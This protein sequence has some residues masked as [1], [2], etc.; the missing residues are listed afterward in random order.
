MG[1][2]HR[3]ASSGASVGARMMARIDVV[4][5]DMCLVMPATHHVWISSYEGREHEHEGKEHEHEGK[6]PADKAK[7]RVLP[8]GWASR[9]EHT[10]YC[11]PTC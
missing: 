4:V 7:T 3:M 2:I 10:P 9:F 5:L 6:E 11:S 1:R 8:S